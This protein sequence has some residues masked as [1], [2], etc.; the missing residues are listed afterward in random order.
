MRNDRADLHRLNALAC[1]LQS[2]A[3]AVMRGEESDVAGCVEEEMRRRGL[4]QGT[5][6]IFG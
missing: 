2:A 1:P 6:K 4:K 3:G 5:F